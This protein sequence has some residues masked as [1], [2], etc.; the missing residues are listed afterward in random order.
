MFLI[1][2]IVNH[3]ACCSALGSEKH[4]VNAIFIISH[5]KIVC[6][7]LIFLLNHMKH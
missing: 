2:I 1:F 5:K 7:H 4:M 3:H 6:L